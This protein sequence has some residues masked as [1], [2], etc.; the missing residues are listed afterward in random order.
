MNQVSVVFRELARLGYN[1]VRFIQSIIKVVNLELHE[2]QLTTRISDLQTLVNTLNTQE[3]N[4]TNKIRQL[5]TQIELTESES[6]AKIEASTTRV[7][8]SLATEGATLRDLAEYKAYRGT[9]MEANI[10]P[11]NTQLIQRI[12]DEVKAAGNPG[13]LARQLSLNETLEARH[14]ELSEQNDSLIRRK[15]Q[16]GA[17]LLERS[18]EISKALAERDRLMNEIQDLRKQIDGYKAQLEL[19]KAELGG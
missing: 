15:G 10:D 6:K 9:L 14:N 3:S 2:N 16:L 19:L 17:E 7:L 18:Q 13:E 5:T 4:L 1:P 11:D 8:D 12:L